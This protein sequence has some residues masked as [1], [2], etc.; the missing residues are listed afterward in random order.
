MLLLS[1]DASEIP[2][3][4]VSVQPR[5]HRGTQTRREKD[6]THMQIT[7]PVDVAELRWHARRH[8]VKTRKQNPIA[9]QDKTRGQLEEDP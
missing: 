3:H 8:E 7:H 2:I 1:C 9:K 6:Q 4:E 5:A